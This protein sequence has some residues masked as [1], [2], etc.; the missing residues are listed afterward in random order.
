LAVIDFLIILGKWFGAKGA[1]LGRHLAV[2]LAPDWGR[3]LAV[4]LG[5]DWWSHLGLELGRAGVRE[6][7]F[8][9]ILG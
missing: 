8:W 6:N 9:E 5:P 1:G 7:F 2:G 4:D 3:H